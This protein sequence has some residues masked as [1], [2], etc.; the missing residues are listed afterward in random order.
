M[1]FQYAPHF[2]TTVDNYTQYLPAAVM[3]GLKVGGVESRSQ[4]G[5]MLV[6][7]AFSAAIMAGVVNTIKLTVDVQ[8][9]DGSAYNSYPSG[10]TATAS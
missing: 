1:R 2:H 4:W 6:S 10:H 9:P 8:R 5:R 7:D 3:L